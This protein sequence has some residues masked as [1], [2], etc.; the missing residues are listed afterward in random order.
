MTYQSFVRSLHFLSFLTID[1][2]IL[3]NPRNRELFKTLKSIFLDNPINNES[4]K[5]LFNDNENLTGL[6]EQEA[7]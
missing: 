3:N 7:R 6:I 2:L 5:Q 1:N 4:V